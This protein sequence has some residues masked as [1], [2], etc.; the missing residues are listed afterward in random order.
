MIDFDIKGSAGVSIKDRQM[1][2]IYNGDMNTL[3][4]TLNNIRIENLWIEE[5][6]LEDIFLHFYQKEE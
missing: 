2:F 6:S 4:E 1:E 3:M 5:P